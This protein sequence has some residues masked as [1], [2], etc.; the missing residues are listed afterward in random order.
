M[1][2]YKISKISRD[3]IIFPMDDIVSL[4]FNKTNKSSFLKKKSFWS[5][6]D[7]DIHSQCPNLFPYFSLENVQPKFI[8]HLL[9]LRHWKLHFELTKQA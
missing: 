3:N 5:L 6:R 7:I 2:L 9:E 1:M 4:F 8:K